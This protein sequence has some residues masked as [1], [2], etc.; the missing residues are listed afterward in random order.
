M[1]SL[2][3]EI[4]TYSLICGKPNKFLHLKGGPSHHWW[5]REERIYQGN[6]AE[7][8]RLTTLYFKRRGSITVGQISEMEDELCR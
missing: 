8:Q 3:T 4:G 6:L 7:F 1:G 2:S 5:K